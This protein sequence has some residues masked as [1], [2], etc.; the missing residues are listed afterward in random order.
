M[1]GWVDP[2]SS[3]EAPPPQY[4]LTR[5]PSVELRWHKGRTLGSPVEEG[6]L[7]RLV[8]ELLG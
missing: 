7:P 1:K 8:V 2:L 6:R 3:D 5:F 4:L